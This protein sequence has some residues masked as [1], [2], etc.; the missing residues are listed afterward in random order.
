M[1]G[2]SKRSW[3]RKGNTATPTVPATTTSAGPV[4]APFDAQPNSSTALPPDEDGAALDG[5]HVIATQTHKS[6]DRALINAFEERLYPETNS[7]HL[8]FGEITITF[9]DV[10]VIL[11]V[12][13]EGMTVTATVDLDFDSQVELVIDTLGIPYKNVFDELDTFCYLSYTWLRK[14]FATVDEDSPLAK[15][16]RAVRAYMLYLFGS[17]LCPNKSGNGVPARF[18]QCFGNL[19]RIPQYSW[20]SVVLT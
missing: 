4:I 13:T 1:H 3:T 19:D 18:L 11:G 8:P 16:Q 6:V 15:K 10:E 7:F 9:Y 5:L 17:I 2:A 12:R 20:G 14:H